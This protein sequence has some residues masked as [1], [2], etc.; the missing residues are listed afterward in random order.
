[1]KSFLQFDGNII[2]ALIGLSHLNPNLGSRQK[3]PFFISGVVVHGRQNLVDPVS[4]IAHFYGSEHLQAFI[5]QSYV[6]LLDRS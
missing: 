6:N 2:V 1:M 5:N 3:L 4:D